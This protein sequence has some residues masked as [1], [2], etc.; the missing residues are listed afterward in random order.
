LQFLQGL[1]NARFSPDRGAT[2]KLLERNFAIAMVF[3]FAIGSIYGCADKL[4]TFSE[5]GVQIWKLNMIFDAGPGFKDQTLV[6]TPSETEMD[7]FV[8]SAD[9]NEE[10]KSPDFGEQQYFMKWDGEVRNGMMQCDIAFRVD[11]FGM[12]YPS[13]QGNGTAKGTFVKS[14]ASGT[15]NIS[16]GFSDT[17]TWTAE[18]ID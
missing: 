1:I 14:R 10:I 13:S 5:P 12:G 3:I 16:T 18:R 8:V 6:L 4:I 11:R 15:F 2:M 7:V 17:G 9:I